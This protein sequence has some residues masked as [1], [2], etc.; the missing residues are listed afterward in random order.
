MN[1]DTPISRLADDKLG[2]AGIARHLAGVFLRNDLSDGLVVGIEGAWGSGKSSLANL[3][4]DILKSEESVLPIVRFSPWIVGSRSELIRELFLEFDGVVYDSLP[5]TSRR[6]ARTLLRRYAQAAPALAEAF[7]AA[8]AAIPFAASVSKT[9]KSTG[10]RAS[11]IATR[12]SAR[13]DNASA[14]SFASCRSPSSSSSTTWTAS[15]PE[16]RSKSFDS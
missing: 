16:K 1:N 12:R 15:N 5:A 7:D 10:D 11:R 2:F 8:G 14:N 6:T 13:S 3:A 4:L 9:L